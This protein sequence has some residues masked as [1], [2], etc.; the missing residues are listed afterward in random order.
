MDAANILSQL[1]DQAWV[2]QV[3]GALVLVVVDVLFGL[4]LAIKSGEFDPGKAANFY[5]TTVLP[6][7]LGWLV[8]NLLIKLVGVLGL[9]DI[10]P[11]V[12]ASI[13]AGAYALLLLTLGA[14]LFDKF[15]ALWGKIPGQE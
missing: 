12:P 6:Y 11:I 7:L 8:L 4:I 15:R 13:E 9:N 3:V 5:K 2:L 14:G 1:F 10:A